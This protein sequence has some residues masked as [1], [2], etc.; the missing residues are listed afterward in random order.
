MRHLRFALAL[1]LAATSSPWATAA[2]TVTKSEDAVVLE[3]ELVRVTLPRDRNFH[4]TAMV[5]KQNPGP[6]LFDDVGFVAWNV[7]RSDWMRSSTSDWQVKLTIHQDKTEAWCESTL[8]LT[9]PNG[10]QSRLTLRTT[11]RSDSPAVELFFH[12]NFQ[13]EHMHSVG[14]QIQASG[15][16]QAEWTTAWGKRDLPLIGRKNSFHALL[17]FQNGL[18]LSHQKEDSQTGLLLFHNEAWNTVFPTLREK[19]QFVRYMHATLSSPAECRIKILPFRGHPALLAAKRKHGVPLGIKIPGPPPHPEANRKTANHTI[20]EADKKRGFVPFVVTPFATV[21]PLSMP[22][23]DSIGKPLRVRACAG[24]YEPASFAIRA[25]QPVRDLSV[26]STDLLNGDLRIP[27]DAIEAH[28][29]KVWRQA[30]PPT[31]ADA[32]LGVGPEVPELLLKDDRV[33]LTGSRPR[34]RLD[35][36]IGTTVEA[37]TTKQIWLTIHVPDKTPPGSYRGRVAV[38]VSGEAVA[39]LPLEVQV[40]PFPL[41]LSRKKQGIWFKAER[42]RD[43]REY[44]ERDVYRRLLDD[45]RAHGMQF[46]TIRGRGLGTAEDV[47][48]IHQSA[49]MTGT[50]IWSSW[51]P[52]SAPDFRPLRANLEAATRKHGYSELLFQAADEPNSEAQIARALAYFQKVKKAGGRTFCNIMPEY[53]VRLGDQLDVP[54]VGYSNF[55]GSIERPEP[56]AGESSEAVSR[57]LKTHEEVWYYWQCRVED[58]RIN[59]LL[60]GFLLMKSPATG[61]MPYTYGTLEAEAPFDDWSALQIGQV[62]R[63]GGGAVYHARDGAVPTIQWEAAREGVDDARY[64]STLEALIQKAAANPKLAAAVARANKSLQAT[65][66]RLPGHL[67]STMARVAPSTLDAMRTEIVEA[68]LTLRQSMA[69]P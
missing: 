45:V 22:P 19:P 15:Y 51:F 65:Y 36:P 2:V 66:S 29:V 38:T 44:V 43:Q 46:V 62:S 8:S 9:P 17:G 63:A 32:T 25:L 58:P 20:T 57:L 47:L 14:L 5:D 49:G 40:L 13:P 35:G 50:A 59:R 67:Y 68:I 53:A 30:G 12:A 64:V 27:A 10:K 21:L 54:C 3:N 23:M 61:A 16:K 26:R 39:H 42:R 18:A 56:I 60:F 37:D 6:S 48:Q 52:S 4:P 7:P 1:A 41:A 24:E 11:L 55:F 28:V 31:M 34:L 69:S 33:K